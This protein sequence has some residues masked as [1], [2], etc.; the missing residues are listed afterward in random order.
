MR[1]MTAHHVTDMHLGDNI[2]AEVGDQVIFL[3]QVFKQLVLLL[4]PVF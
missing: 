4:D 2:A 3:L 1:G